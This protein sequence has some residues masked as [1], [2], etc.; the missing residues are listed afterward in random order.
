MELTF[1]HVKS[2]IF[3]FLARMVLQLKAE[4]SE[5]ILCRANVFTMTIFNALELALKLRSFQL[6]SKKLEFFQFFFDFQVSVKPMF[7][8]V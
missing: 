1:M 3:I 4:V 8:I 2:S 6:F 5:N 7:L